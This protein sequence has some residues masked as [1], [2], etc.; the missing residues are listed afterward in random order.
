MRRMLFKSLV[1]GPLTEAAPAADDAALAELA[2][3]VKEAARSA[4]GPDA[5][6]SRSG[7]GFLQR[8]RA[9]NPCAQQHRLRSRAV[10]YALRRI[11]APRRRAPRHGTGHDEHA[12]SAGAHLPCDAGSEMGRRRRRLRARRWRVFRQLCVRGR[13]FCGSP[14]RS[15]HPRLPSLADHAAQRAAGTARDRATR[16]RVSPRYP[17]GRRQIAPP[18]VVRG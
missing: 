3:R 9:R 14:G 13:R 11:A 8:L 2:T 1:H 18:I 15:A 12:R 5:L 17:R 10:R 7:R 4:P 16:R 6:H